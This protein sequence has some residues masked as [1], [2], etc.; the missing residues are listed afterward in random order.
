MNPEP[1]KPTRIDVE[2]IKPQPDRLK[3]SGDGVFAT[4][5][6]EGLTAG[7]ESVFLRLQFCNLTCGIPNGW[8]CDTGYTWDRTRSEFWQEP[9]DWSYPDAA[10]RIK[11]AWQNRFGD[12]QDGRLVITG[13]EPLLQQRK[14]AN[15]LQELP[16]W[17]VEIETNGTIMPIDELSNCQFNCSPK[18]ENSGNALKRRYRPEVLRAIN[19]LPKSQFKFVVVDSSDLEEVAG[20]VSECCLDPNKVVIMPE[21]Q[22]KEAVEEHERI[23]RD[24]VLSHG[25]KIILRNQLI[26]FGPKRRT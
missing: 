4:L 15:L 19:E 21:G 6:G 10:L 14:I 11:Q 23:I 2:R 8:Q 9:E 17:D 3:V 13:G 25:W 1:Y 22:T 12:N 16:D 5:Q 20:I 26:W 24:A 18:L 7:A